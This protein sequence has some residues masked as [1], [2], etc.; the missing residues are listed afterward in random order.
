MKR[1]KDGEYAPVSKVGNLGRLLGLLRPYPWLLP[2][3]I[4]LGIAASLAEAI[5][6]GL[7]I[8]LLGMLLQPGDPESLS[9]FEQLVRTLMTDETGVVRL[10]RVAV[11]IMG[12]ILLKTLILSAFAFVA[13]GMT[14][15]IARDLRVSLWDRVINAEMA[16]FSRSNHGR[17]LNIIE[18]QTYRATEA[19]SM[20]TMI[21]VSGSTVLVFGVALFL[22]STPLALVVFAIGAPVFLIV[23]RL[24]SVANRLGHELGTMHS[25][26]AGRVIE[27]LAAMKTIR[28]FNRQAQ[29]TER[30]AAAAEGLRMTFFR[31][32]MLARLVP[33]VL[34]LIYLPVFFAVIAYALFRGVGTPVLLAFV[35]LLYR[36][37]APVKLLD[38]ARV[39]MAEYTPALADVAWLLESVP[40]ERTR[41]GGLPSSGCQDQII[42]EDLWFTYPGSDLPALRGIAT[43]MK[44]GEVIA[45]VGPS[46]S[47]KSTLVNLLFGLYVPDAGRILIDGQPLDTTDINSWRD[48]IAFSGQDSELVNGS[49]RYNITYGVAGA[50]EEVVETIARS[51][52][53]HDFLAALPEGY[54]TDLG[55]R[56][57][58]LS[59]GQR[60]RVALAR[61]LM[62]KPD[63]LVLDEATNAVDTETELAIQSTIAGLAGRTTILIIAHRTSTLEYADRVLVLEEGRIV[64]DGPPSCISSRAALLA[65]IR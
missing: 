5:G 37:Q 35:L 8:P 14:G 1:G 51:V 46:G 40:D 36:M 65:G 7:L 12:L 3:L 28:V 30:F 6:I 50:S 54:D 16:W 53:A 26:L 18:N 59:G 55:S 48:H 44:R 27:L 10:G 42:L 29:E 20:L 38:G 61:A 45:L 58:L 49:A 11:S 4:V 13:T 31:S 22:L 47:G 21:I 34:E 64:E 17:L 9:R 2:L 62:R 19:L 57:I 56:G 24:T 23:R 39:A 60:Q 52:H 32:E 33:P 15:Q 43:T 63:L 41:A 25:E